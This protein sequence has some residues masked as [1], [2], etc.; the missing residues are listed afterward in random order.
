VVA[1]KFDQ[2]TYRDLANRFS[3]SLKRNGWDLLETEPTYFEFWM[4]GYVAALRDVF[5]EPD[6]N[7][8]PPDGVGK[9]I[10]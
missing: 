9:S 1:V 3:D 5:R 6:L 7:I 10:R 4:M 8:A 2:T